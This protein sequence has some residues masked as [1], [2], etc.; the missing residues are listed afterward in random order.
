MSVLAKLVSFGY[1]DGDHDAV[2]HVF[3]VASFQE[4]SRV[5]GSSGFWQH[6]G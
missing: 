2:R 4:V 5:Q 6:V 1:G 3:D